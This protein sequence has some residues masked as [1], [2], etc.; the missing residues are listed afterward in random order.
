M[1]KMV[2]ELSDDDARRLADRAGNAH[3]TPERLAAE[4]VRTYL[5]RRRALSFVGLFASGTHDTAA[6]SEE[7]L[8]SEL[9]S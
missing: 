8:R 6:R 7:I 2:I 5:D 4:A 9:G 1:R 3:V